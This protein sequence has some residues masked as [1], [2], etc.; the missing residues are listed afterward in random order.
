MLQP[1]NAPSIPNRTS[2]VHN[3]CFSPGDTYGLAGDIEQA[4]DVEVIGGE[5]EFEQ[6][7]LV[8]LEELDVPGGNVIGPLLAVVVIFRRRRVVLVIR[9]PLDHFLQ[10]GEGQWK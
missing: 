7:P 5:D 1:N 10:T 3:N 4:L 2:W 9:A 8:H 6:R